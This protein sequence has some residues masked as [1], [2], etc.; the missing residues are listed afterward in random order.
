MDYYCSLESVHT[1][2]S[3]NTFEKVFFMILSFCQK[4]KKIKSAKSAESA[5]SAK[6]SKSAE[7]GKSAKSANSAESEEAFFEGTLRQPSK[8]PAATL[9]GCATTLQGPY[10]NSPR[11][12]WQLSK[13][14]AATLQGPWVHFGQTR[15]SV[16]WR[17]FTPLNRENDTSHPF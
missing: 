9:Q 1:E 16:F 14:P 7:S 13:D 17:Y 6:L 2:I 3:K 5:K 11:T 4:D 10:S 15:F 8:Q 12:L